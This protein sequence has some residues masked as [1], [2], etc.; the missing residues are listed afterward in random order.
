MAQTRCQ[1]LV[2][3]NQTHNADSR[4][5]APREAAAQPRSPEG[6]PQQRFDRER[7]RGFESPFLRRRVS[8]TGAFRACPRKDPA[9]AGSESLDETR[10]WD[11]LA[12]SRLASSLFL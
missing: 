12:A 7:D 2:T 1:I 5:R 11:V 4:H 3:H 8:L 10:E 6:V 9:F